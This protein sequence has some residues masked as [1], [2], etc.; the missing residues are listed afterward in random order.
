[1][2]RYGRMPQKPTEEKEQ[3]HPRPLYYFTIKLQ[4]SGSLKKKSA[5]V[6]SDPH[7]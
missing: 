3:L 7:P 4:S 6:M 2:R 5:Y 1:M